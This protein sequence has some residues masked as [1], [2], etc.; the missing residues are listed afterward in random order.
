MCDKLSLSLLCKKKKKKKRYS[1]SFISQHLVVLPFS[2]S[3]STISIS[4]VTASFIITVSI[5]FSAFKALSRGSNEIST[6]P[7]VTRFLSQ[8]VALDFHSSGKPF[9]SRERLHKKE[10]EEAKDINIKKV[11]EEKEKEETLLLFFIPFVS[12]INLFI[13]LRIYF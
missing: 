10:S 1:S 9:G 3:L 11:E 2:R 7:S 12:E 13:L 8:S 4:F 5:R 6:P